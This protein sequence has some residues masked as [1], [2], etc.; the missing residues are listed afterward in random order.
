MGRIYLPRYAREHDRIIAIPYAITDRN[1]LFAHLLLLSGL[2]VQDIC[3][4][5]LLNI[6][7]VEH[8]RFAWRQHGKIRMLIVLVRDQQPFLACVQIICK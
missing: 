4:C 7:L 5:R 2:Q 1:K 8:E 6:H 3:V